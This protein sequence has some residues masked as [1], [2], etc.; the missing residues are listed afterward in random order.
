MFQPFPGTRDEQGLRA[1]LWQNALVQGIYTH[2][3]TYA[4]THAY[5]CTFARAFTYTSADTY[6]LDILHIYIIYTYTYTHTYIF[7]LMMDC[8]C[9]SMCW[10]LGMPVSCVTWDWTERINVIFWQWMAFLKISEVCWRWIKLKRVMWAKWNLQQW[11]SNCF[12]TSELATL[13]VSQAWQ[14][15]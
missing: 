13:P 3:C 15:P 2:A 11:V 1:K 12:P 4:Y 6:Y 9:Y 10:G 8:I 14:L 7:L 5:R